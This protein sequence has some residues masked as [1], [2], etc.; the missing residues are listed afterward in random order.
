MLEQALSVH[1]LINTII[2]WIIVILVV[3]AVTELVVQADIFIEV[4]GWI[5]RHSNFFGRLVSC[6]Y[7]A[8]VWVSAGLAWILPPIINMWFI[9][10][11]LKTFAVHRISNILHEAFSR[12]L[13]RYPR[14]YVHTY[15]NNGGDSNERRN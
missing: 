9:D 12:W 7:C 14:T 3:E 10:I 5:S 2:A 4:R 11:L 15:I 8:S 6:G 13:G 1:I